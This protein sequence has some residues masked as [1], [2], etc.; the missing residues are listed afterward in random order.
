[1]I[2]YLKKENSASNIS[3]KAIIVVIRS[4][5]K[6]LNKKA[7][8][9]NHSQKFSN[10]NHLNSIKITVQQNKFY[11]RSV[12]KSQSNKNK[13]IKHNQIILEHSKRIKLLHHNKKI[14]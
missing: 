3:S 7:Q 6:Y 4:L 1:M 12:L 9:S 11:L 8:N 2:S 10:L 13:K 5:E 14:I